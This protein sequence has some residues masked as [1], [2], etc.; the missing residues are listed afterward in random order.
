MAIY[1]S[2]RQ[3]GAADGRAPIRFLPRGARYRS[4]RRPRNPPA[5]Q[6]VVSTCTG[7]DAAHE[8]R[9]RQT[10]QIALTPPPEQRPCSCGPALRPTDDQR[11]VLKD[12][13]PRRG[14]IPRCLSTGR[15]LSDAHLAA[16][17]VR[18]SL[19][20]RVGFSAVSAPAAF[21]NPPTT[22]SR[23]RR[24]L[25]RPRSWSSSLLSCR[26]KRPASQDD[27]DASAYIPTSTV[28]SASP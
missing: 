28:E 17:G 14:T 22:T 27:L 11:L 16:V 2:I 25:L 1:L 24:R 26:P 4:C 9:G 15:R 5:R 12:L 20:R 13:E 6:R 8:Q 21:S 23:G 18:L 10:S 7:I 3:H 19:A